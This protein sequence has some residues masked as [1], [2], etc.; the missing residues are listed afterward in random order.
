MGE[1]YLLCGGMGKI[2]KGEKLL[3]CTDGFYRNLDREEL[4]VWGKRK[5]DSDRMADRM[6]R[7]IFQK[8]INGGERDNISALYFGYIEQK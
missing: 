5:V 8:K 4:R 3:L 1:W 6:L 7:Q 2:K